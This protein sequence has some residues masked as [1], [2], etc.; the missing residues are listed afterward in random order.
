M[1]N[2]SQI[3]IPESYRLILIESFTTET[4]GHKDD[5]FLFRHQAES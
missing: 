2:A 5:G 4:T 3:Q 1:L